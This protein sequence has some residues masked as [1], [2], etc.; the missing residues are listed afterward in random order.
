[1]GTYLLTGF[2]GFIGARL[3]PRLL[4]LMPDASL[5]CLVQPQFA[6]RARL[7]VAALEGR[8]PTVRGRLRTAQG[9]ITVPGLGLSAPFPEPVA[10]AFHLAAAYDLA[11]S[12]EVGERVN[13]QGTR[14]VLEFLADAPG[15]PHLHYVSTAYVSGD[16]TGIFRETDLDV[17]QAFKN[18]Y[19]ETKFLAER[20][21]V[22][23]GL[24]ATIY[25]PGIVVGDSRTGETAKFDGPYFALR[26]MQ[27]LP[28]PGLFIRIGSGRSPLNVV[29]V[30]F[31]VEGLARL[32][33]DPASRGRTYH[34]TDPDPLPVV[35]LTRRMAR[36]LE[37]RLWLVPV[38]LRL[39][40][41][42]LRPRLVRSFLGLP[43]EALAYFDH[44]CRYDCSQATESLG[45]L[46]VRCPSLPD[47]L[48]ALVAFYRSARDS[49]GS[50]AML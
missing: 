42:A 19:E 28:S 20:A 7:D 37:R 33:A 26:A 29:P 12:R 39:A 34:L 18:H 4:E 22:E 41:L 9:D 40:E 16:A 27:A 45:R 50:A 46:G 47:Y 17:G 30:D 36:A 6:E 21:V 24:P 32:A 15:G 48:D 43:L 2:P 35:E 1:V 23:S 49:V 31:V 11:V 8:F 13:V 14:N 3:V 5:C 38:P 44:P 10:G 25:R